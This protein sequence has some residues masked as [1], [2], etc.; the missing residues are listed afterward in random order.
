MRPLHEPFGTHLHDAGQIGLI[1]LNLEKTFPNGEG[2]FENILGQLLFQIAI[3]NLAGIVFLLEVGY[4][5]G[6]RN[7]L[8]QR[9]E[10]FY[11]LGLGRIGHLG[12]FVGHGTHDFLAQGLLVVNQIDA[13]TLRL[14]HLAR[15]VE[16]GHLDRFAAEVEILRFGKI[17]DAIGRVEAASKTTGQLQVLFLV[18]AHRHIVTVL[19]KNID[20]HECGVCEQTGIHPLVGVVAYNLV[21][22]IFIAIGLDAQLLAS[23]ILERGG[24]HQLTDTHVHIH[25]Q[26]HLRDFR[27]IALY[28]KG[29][30]L[31]VESGSQIFT[32]DVAHILVQHLGIGVSREGMPIGYKE[33]AVVLILLLHFYKITQSTIIISQM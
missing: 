10:V 4:R 27:H 3:A 21:L 19:D 17:F 29:R 22:D 7:N 18:L 2:D 32:K 31:G 1:A 33:I 11:R 12:T 13:V 8:E 30:F 28:K 5:V 16:P 20:R 15:T 25:Q 6:R 24:T 26:I 23:L 9:K 14:T